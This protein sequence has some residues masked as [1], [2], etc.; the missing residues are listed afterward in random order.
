M[1]Y[2]ALGELA[3]GDAEKEPVILTASIV[4]AETFGTPAVLADAYPLTVS[5]GIASGETFGTPIITANGVVGNPRNRWPGALGEFAFGETDDQTFY[6]SA[7]GN[8]ASAE[9][10]GTPAVIGDTPEPEPALFAGSVMLHEYMRRMELLR[11]DEE[12]L[13]L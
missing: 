12:L 11:E 5:A 6:I 13:I 4:S 2:G 3:L 1:I 10:F 7:A 9:I 8:I